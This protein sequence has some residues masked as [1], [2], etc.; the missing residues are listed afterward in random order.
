MKTL[1]VAGA[2]LLVTVSISALDT[3]HRVMPPS[4]DGYTAN[5][6]DTTKKKKD[7]KKKDTTGR[8]TSYVMYRR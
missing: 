8:D 2:A 7:K 6:Q 3:G 1:L 5:Y 4:E